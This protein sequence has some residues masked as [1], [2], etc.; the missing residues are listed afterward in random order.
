MRLHSWLP[1]AA[2]AGLALAGAGCDGG[3]HMVTTPTGLKYIDLKE[4]E[5]PSAKVGDVVDVHYTATLA[6]GKKF[7]STRDFLRPDRFNVG[8]TARWLVPGLDEGV[9]GMKAGGKRRLI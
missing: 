2:L 3:A 6:T 8:G 9:E 5:G 1:A 7:R 4:G